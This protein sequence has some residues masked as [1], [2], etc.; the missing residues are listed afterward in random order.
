MGSAAGVEIVGQKPMVRR[1]PN[2]ILDLFER[3]ISGRAVES[4]TSAAA[5]AVRIDVAARMRHMWD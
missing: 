5:S 4:V 3:R 2:R 1:L